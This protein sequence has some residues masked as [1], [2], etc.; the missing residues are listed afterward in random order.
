MQAELPWRRL[1]GGSFSELDED[2][3]A[4]VAEQ[5]AQNRSHVNLVASE[6]YA[7]VATISAEASELVNKNA[8][9][10]PPRVSFGGGH[11]IDE[12]EGLAI[13]RAKALFGA[14]HANVQALSSTIANVAVLRALLDRGDRVLAF[15]MSAGGHTSHGHRSHIS[16]QDY[17]VRQ[18]GLDSQTGLVDYDEV[19]RIAQEFRPRI[20][21]AGSSSYPRQ[22][23]FSALSNIARE[24]GALM[25]A[26][27]A[28]VVGLVIAELHP[29]PV[30]MSDVVTTSTHK[31]LCGPRT[32]GLIL[33][34]ARY[35]AQL[36]AAVTPTLQA[37]PGAHIIAA[38]AVLFRIVASAEFSALMRRVVAN[39]A[40][41]AAGLARSSATLFS[42]GTDTHMVVVDL[43]ETTWLEADLNHRL[44]EAGI[45][46]NATG[47]PR[48][49]GTDSRL[50]LR[51][52]TTPMSIRGL[53][54][55]DFEAIGDGVARLLRGRTDDELRKRMTR[56]SREFPVPYDW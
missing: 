34:K 52:G 32:G 53:R 8:S 46:A 55:A 25:F 12:I 6:S 22:L 4:L 36:D 14:E 1:F 42:G 27:I 47:L 19:R 38:R 21:I 35:G 45:I 44:E 51:L 17:V 18:F 23:D 29:N 15:G 48:R 33:S 54:E 39:A 3:S 16:G 20:I 56:L 11:V 50:G 13:S 9:G 7:P 49:E 26:D 40:A 24:S 30:V 31:T 10:Y 43:R 28:H 41:L 5:C 2:V 37:A